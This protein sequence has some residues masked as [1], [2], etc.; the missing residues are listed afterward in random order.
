MSQADENEQTSGSQKAQ[1]A[2]KPDRF[3]KARLEKLEKIVELGLDPF[4]QRFDNHMSIKEARELVPAESLP[5]RI[6]NRRTLQ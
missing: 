6:N 2:Q 1:K 5:N 3:E 4:G